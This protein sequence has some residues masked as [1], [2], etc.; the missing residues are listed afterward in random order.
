MEV[1][2]YFKHLPPGLI[3]SLV[4]A[5]TENEERMKEMA[6]FMESRRKGIG[7]KNGFFDLTSGKLT[8]VS[9]K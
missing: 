4:T 8:G 9:V 1:R 5:L 7:F 3:A 2:R 6:L